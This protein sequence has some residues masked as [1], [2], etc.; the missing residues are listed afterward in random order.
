MR[1]FGCTQLCNYHYNQN[2]IFPPLQKVLLYLLWVN[3]FLPSLSTW[4]HLTCFLYLRFCLLWCHIDGCPGASQ[5]ALVS[6][7][8]TRQCRR[9]KRCGFDPLGQEDLLEE[10][11]ATHSSIPTH[12]SSTHRCPEYINTSYKSVIRQTI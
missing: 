3:H 8:P 4:Q 5:V 1:N 11:M 10:G 6:K 2:R 12:S 7:E 9:R